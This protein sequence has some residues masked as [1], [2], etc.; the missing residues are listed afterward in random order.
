MTYVRTEVIHLKLRAELSKIKNCRGLDH[1]L[2]PS[3]IRTRRGAS[4]EKCCQRLSF[5]DLNVTASSR[6]DLAEKFLFDRG[7]AG[8]DVPIAEPI[9]L[10][11]VKPQLLHR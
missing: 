9:M 3:A 5:H 10:G 7:L 6:T 11:N 1:Y 2:L 4:P 8:L